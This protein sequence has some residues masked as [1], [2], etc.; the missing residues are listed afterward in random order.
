M[1]SIIS[2]FPLAAILTGFILITPAA[3]AKEFLT[4]EEIEEIQEAQEIDKRVEIY[5]DAAALRLKEAENRLRGIE[6]MEGDPL[7]FYTPEDMLDGYYRI[8]RS[9]MF[10]LDDAV[11]KPGYDREKLKKA[12]KNLKGK[13]EDAGKPLEVLKKLAEQ[14]QKEAFWNLVNEAIDITGGAYEGAEFGLEKMKK[15]DEDIERARERRR[16]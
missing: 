15:E 2:L 9:V 11:Q 10:N 3:T 14:K 13:T 6:S 16:Q 1:Q 8:L 7:E 4:E 12:L 5:L